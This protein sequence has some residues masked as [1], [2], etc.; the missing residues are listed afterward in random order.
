[1]GIRLAAPGSV[2]AESVGERLFDRI[3]PVKN[4]RAMNVSRAELLRR[5]GRELDLSQLVA[6]G[7][8]GQK[9]GK[10]FYEHNG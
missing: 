10:G 6:A 1:M 7:N 4:N 3:P 5:G 2:N 9:T 8:L